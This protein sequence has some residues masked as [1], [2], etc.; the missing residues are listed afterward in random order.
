[1]INDW[2]NEIWDNYV[3]KDDKLLRKNEFIKFVKTIFKMSNSIYEPTDRELNTLFSMI[4]L[5]YGKATKEKMYIFLKNLSKVQPPRIKR[6]LEDMDVTSEIEKGKANQE[7][8]IEE[9][10]LDN[11][12]KEVKVEDGRDL[13]YP[14]DKKDQPPKSDEANDSNKQG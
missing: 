7:A 9:A 8:N 5:E 11:S 1:M 10:D 12:N 3:K 2:L 13:F 4:G 14:K 6:P